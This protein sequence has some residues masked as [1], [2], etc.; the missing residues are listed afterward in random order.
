MVNVVLSLLANVKV[1]IDTTGRPIYTVLI[2]LAIQLTLANVVV[3][4][5]SN[6]HH[7]KANPAF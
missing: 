6:S 1:Y 5:G 2:L 3:H 7:T 4:N